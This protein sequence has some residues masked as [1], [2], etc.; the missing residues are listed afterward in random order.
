MYASL[1]YYGVNDAETVTRNVNEE[2]LDI[3][4]EVPGFSAYQLVDLGDGTMVSITLTDDEA[5]A[6]A[7]TERAAE[8]LG[9]NEE[10]QNAVKGPPR[11]VSG[12]I[13]ASA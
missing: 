4:R 2:F 5:G 3:L 11:V 1:R 10:M 13:T 9:G 6:D 7:S 12:E 8:W